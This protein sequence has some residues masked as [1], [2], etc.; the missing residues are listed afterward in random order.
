MTV[1]RKGAR[2]AAHALRGALNGVV[3]QLEVAALA[4]AR[5]DEAMLDK[6]LAAARK[7]AAEASEQVAAL[8]AEAEPGAADATGAGS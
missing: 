2:E 4:R 1:E 8:D 6:A 5:G 3:L 7:A